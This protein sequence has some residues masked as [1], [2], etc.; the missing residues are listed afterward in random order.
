MYDFDLS[1]KVIFLTGATGLLGSSYAK[2]LAKNNASLILCDIDLRSTDKLAESISNKYNVKTI[3]LFCDVCDKASIEECA[4]VGYKKFGKITSVINNAA[5]TGEFLM[6][7]GKLFTEFSDFDLELWNATIKTNLTGPFLVAQVVEK[8]LIEN[9]G[10][11][12]VNVSSTYGVV[13]PDHSMYEGLP[14]NS[15]VAYAS[16]KAGIHGLTRWLSTYWGKHKIRVNTLVPGGVLNN[17]DE[18]FVSRYSERT[19]L[20]RMANKED[21]PGMVIY[22]LSDMSQYCTGQQYFVDGGW[23]AR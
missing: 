2:F 16:S 8:Y 23:T 22:L 4:R 9:G 12:V 11:S 5:A 13:G 1:G 10:G 21:M 6:K 20:E 15:T 3:G 17:H 18:L 19:P 14:F 7:K